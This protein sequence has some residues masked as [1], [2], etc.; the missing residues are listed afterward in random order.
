MMEM[1]QQTAGAGKTG[2]GMFKLLRIYGVF[3]QLEETHEES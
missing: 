2:F 1:R 3:R